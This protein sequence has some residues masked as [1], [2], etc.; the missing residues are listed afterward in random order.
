MALMASQARSRA[1]ASFLLERAFFK[2]AT[3]LGNGSG[4]VH[5]GIHDTA[6][7]L[8]GASSSSMSPLMKMAI[9]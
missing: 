3:A 5:S 7:H 9:S 4:T 1:R 8:V 6:T 2:V